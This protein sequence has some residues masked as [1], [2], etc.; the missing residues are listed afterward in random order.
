[1]LSHHTILV[2]AESCRVANERSSEKTSVARTVTACGTRS[3]R[4]PLQDPE[5]DGAE[6]VCVS[7]HTHQLDNRVSPSSHELCA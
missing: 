1:M 6:K 2:R 4:P 3:F 7:P 5:D